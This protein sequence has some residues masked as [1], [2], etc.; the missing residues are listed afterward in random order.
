MITAVD[1]GTFRVQLDC[2]DYCIDGEIGKEGCDFVV[3]PKSVWL[4]KNGQA[5]ELIHDES[6]R[7][8]IVADVMAWGKAQ[9]KKIGV[10]E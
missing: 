5:V 2:T 3:S 1:R 6:L 10:W 8:R 7:A 9:S 4:L